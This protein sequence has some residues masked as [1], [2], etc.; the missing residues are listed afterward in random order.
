MS[1]IVPGLKTLVFEEREPRI[2]VVTMNRAE[3]LNAI[4]LEMLGEFEALFEA[5]Y[6]DDTIRVLVI[7]GAG[8]GFSSGAD[9]ND[10]V[11][12]RD[13]QAFADPENFLKIVQERYASLILRMRRIPQPVIAA[14]N[15]PA[16]GGGFS[17]ALASDVRFASPEAYFVASFINIGLSGGELGC[18]YLLPRLVGLSR[19]SEILLTGRK[20]R[21]EEAE[22]MGLVTRVVA[23]DGLLEES[24]ACA[25]A[26]AAKSAG[27]LKLTKRALDENLAAPSLESAINIENRNQTIMVFSGEFFKLIRS[28]YKGEGAPGE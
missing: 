28:F 19:A 15:G 10:A 22:R 16:A 5:L 25:R 3:Q 13:S 2:G 9:L 20:V 4:N 7:T 23:G 6:R 12:F 14:V 27:G 8:R 17:M 24:L 21:A 1:A 26:M 18:S 11:V